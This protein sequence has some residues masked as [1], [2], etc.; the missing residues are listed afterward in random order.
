MKQSHTF[1]KKQSG[2]WKQSLLASDVNSIWTELYRIVSSHPLARS[3]RQAGLFASDSNGNYFSDLTQELFVRLHGKGRFEHYIESGMSDKEIEC[4]ISQLELKNMLT[5][6]LR[7]RFPE[8][9]RIARRIA[10]LLH[11]SPCFRRF[12]SSCLKGRKPRRVAEQI[13]GLSEWKN[14]KL[15]EEPSDIEARI[16]LIPIRQRDTRMVGRTG[17]AQIVIS[18]ADL[19]EL[20]IT[21]LET[22]DQPVSIRTLRGLVMSRLLI[23]D[24]NTVSLTEEKD[25]NASYFAPVDECEDA[26]ETLLRR[27]S[28]RE[29]ILQTDYFLERLHTLTK[30]K[31]KQTRRALGVLWYCYLLRPCKTQI[32][33]AA[34]LG[35]SGSLVSNY[36]CRIEKELKTLRF[37]N[38]EIARLFEYNL[39][40]RLKSEWAT[41]NIRTPENK[42]AEGI[43]QIEFSQVE[44]E[45][46]AA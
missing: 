29:A 2:K 19:E 26:E 35:V 38:I 8:S 27:E 5:T 1:C 12:D 15:R 32:E 46:A 6:E 20:I 42:Y 11:N 33:A 45:L 21:V 22:I 31:P 14:K 34:L 39:R 36:C 16:K 9:Y 4:E 41:E 13:Y 44:F 37:P 43:V 18:N 7:K 25:D 23:L 10:T 30:F 40:E 17:D 3:T 28:E 24:I